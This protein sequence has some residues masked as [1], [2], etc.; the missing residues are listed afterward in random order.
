M[1]FKE[2]ASILSEG[3]VSP[4]EQINI[5]GNTD[6]D[7]VLESLHSKMPTGTLYFRRVRCIELSNPDEHLSRFVWFLIGFTHTGASNINQGYGV[8]ILFS[9]SSEYF[10]V[11]RISGGTAGNSIVW[12]KYSAIKS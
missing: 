12:S 2:I 5:E 6:V 4:I 3:G 8:Q 1:K 7:G 11:V 9:Y 10:Y